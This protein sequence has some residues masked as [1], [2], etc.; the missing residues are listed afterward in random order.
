[1]V[2]KCLTLEDGLNIESISMK[3]HTL[4]SECL[5]SFTSPFDFGND[6]DPFMQR[7]TSDSSKT[8]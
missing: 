6:T 8:C 1:M 7:E 4:L 3:V 5:G 2:S